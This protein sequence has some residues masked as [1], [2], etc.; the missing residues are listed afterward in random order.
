VIARLT[1][2]L[3]VYVLGALLLVIAGLGV[4]GW[5]LR[6][7][8]DAQLTRTGAIELQ[9][10]Q[11]TATL[12]QLAKDALELKAS[13]AQAQTAMKVVRRRTEDSVAAGLNDTP[14]SDQ[15]EARK[16]AI[17]SAMADLEQP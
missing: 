15:E 16:K 1:G 11:Q 3:L 10:G 4:H 14:P 5:F 7:Q 8:L 12:E 9:L 6:A 17:A 13:V 2:P